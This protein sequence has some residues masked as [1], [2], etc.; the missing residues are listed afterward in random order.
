MLRWHVI[1]AVFWRNLKQYFTSVLG[2]LFIVAFVT[3]CVLLA[4]SPRFFADNLANLDQLSAYYPSLLLLFVPAI[5]MPLWADE[6]RQGTD[7]ILFTLP[8]SD[9]DILLGKYFAAVAVY[10]IALLFSVTQLVVLASLGEPDW[11]VVGTTYLGYWLS[12]AALISVGMFASSLTASTTVAF[13]LGAT[14]CAVPVLGSYLGQ[15]LSL[16]RY[17]FEWHL[18]D[19]TIGQISLVSV[20]YFVAM[21]VLMLYLNMVVISYRHWNRGEAGNVGWQYVVRAIALAVGLIALFQIVDVSPTTSMAKVDMTNE[22]LFTLSDVTHETLKKVQDSDRK[23]TIQAFVSK[24]MPQK[25]T[26]V[27]KYFDGMLRQY[28]SAGGENVEVLLK[29]V[30][31]NSPREIEAQKLG[32]VAFDDKSE[33][34]GIIKQRKVYLGA[35]VQSSVGESVLP[36]I[37]STR[38]ME[39][40]L[41]HAIFTTVEKGNKL[42][43]GILE[44]DAHFG[45]PEVDGRR[46]PWAYNGTMDVLK[47]RFKVKYHAG[48]DLASFLPQPEPPADNSDADDSDADDAKSDDSKEE[49]AEP[50]KP[51]KAPDVLIVADPASLDDQALDSLVQYLKAGNPAVILADPLPFFWAYQN[52]VNLGVLNAPRMDRVGPQSPYA[53]ILSS[54]DRPKAANGAAALFAE[55]GVEWNS[56]AAVWNTEDPHPGFTPEWPAYLGDRWPEYYGPY[57]KAFVFVKENQFGPAFDQDESISRGLREL[58]FFYPGYFKPAFSSK[59][60]FTTLA[61]IGVDSGKTEWDQLTKTPAQKVQLLNP[62]T[63]ELTVREEPARSEITGGPLKVLNPNPLTV[64]DETDYCVAARV[65]DH[66]DL[67]N[68]LDVVLISDLDFLSDLATAQDEKLDQEV[69]QQLDNLSLFL[70]AIEVLGGTDGFVEL[71]NRRQTPRTL[72]QLESIIKKYRQSRLSQQQQIEEKVQK[73]L[74]EAQEKLNVAT[75]EIQGNESLSFL[76]KLQKTSQRATDVQKQF[77]IKQRRLNR[78]MEKEITELKATEQSLIEKEKR[79]FRFM[80]ALIAPLPA[81]ML[82]MAV[83]WFRIINEQRNINPKRRV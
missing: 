71:R 33:E 22:K 48:S 6:R 21:T 83:L 4:F 45:G 34:D 55:L 28:D 39:Y 65:Q 81:M 32:I 43:V 35:H 30:T 66:Q 37:D 3:V 50:K 26:N 79:F 25:F 40:E 27:R 1:S 53:R 24:D 5:T 19:F 63:G 31:P 18:Q 57:E 8:A 17:S 20:L 52:P 61:T 51:R 69:N 47:Q 73:E 74:E 7:S 14:F 80:P 38:S 64:V 36:F 77:D 67:E 9:F 41:S 75:A 12:G 62:R 54:S 42:T 11:N 29:T 60:Q 2:Y 59:Y 68:G 46:L 58:L 44:S 23:I 70:N 72:V 76:E 10:T 13:I 16:E 78:E 49:N 56:G 82:G 15:A